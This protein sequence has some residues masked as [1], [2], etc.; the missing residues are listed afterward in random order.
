MIGLYAVVNKVTN[1]AYVGSSSNVSARLACHRW[2]INKKRFLHNQSYK[3]DACKYGIENF[4]FKVLRKCETVEEARELETA[5][6]ECFVGQNLYN[7]APSADGATGTK[8]NPA[9]YVVGAA[10]RISDPG[11]KKKLS[12]ACKGK[13]QVV[14][15]PHC[16]VSG[17]GG[18]MRRYHFDNCNNR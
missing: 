4:E 6:L 18:N 14:V 2:A 12:E 16:G 9:N 17:G 3:E 15:C 1:K 5:F 7:I 8:R 13:R 10:K 11:F